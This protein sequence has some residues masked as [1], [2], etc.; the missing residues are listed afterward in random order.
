[1]VDRR[2][3]VLVAQDVVS[4]YGKRQ[5]LNGVSLEVFGGEIVALIGHNGA[6]KSTFLK[7]LFGL[8]PIWSG[9]VIINGEHFCSPMPL[10]LLRKGVVYLPQGSRVFGELTLEE[11][12]RIGGLAVLSPRSLEGRIE[13]ALRT[14]PGLRAQSQQRARSLSGGEKQMLALARALIL[15]PRLL[16]LDEPSLGL[17]PSWTRE[18]LA[19]IERTSRE[20]GAAV[21]IVEQR[22]R[23]VLR[24]A[25]RVYVLRSGS[26]SYAGP[27]DSL[28][29]E[30]RLRE[31]FL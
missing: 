8:L 4:G 26:I 23:E 19:R 18:A 30:A 13:E 31:A 25:Q 20:T 14:F 11:N 24:I 3:A 15:S 27:A 1:M 2:R 29:D 6:G 16:L 22:V 7:A 12:L 21:L 10:E 28:Q 17:S 9:R 5:V